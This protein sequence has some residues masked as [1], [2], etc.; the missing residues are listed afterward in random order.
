MKAAGVTF[1][2]IVT[3]SP[4]L[5]YILNSSLIC[6]GTIPIDRAEQASPAGGATTDAKFSF[7]ASERDLKVRASAVLVVFFGS[8]Y[9][10]TS[11]LVVFCGYRQEE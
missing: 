5:V 7:D 6:F 1:L 8:Y 4:Y 10:T 11:V 2:S 3:I 9:C